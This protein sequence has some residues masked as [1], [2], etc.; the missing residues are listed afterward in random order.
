MP[1][2][3]GRVAEI[4]RFPVKSMQGGR[5][6]TGTFTEQGLDGDRRWALRDVETGRLVSA[7]QNRLILEASAELDGE[8]LTIALPDGRRLS[9]EDPDAEDTLSTWLGRK[10]VLEHA[11][12]QTSEPYEFY[13][14][15]EDETSEAIEFYTSE[16]SFMDAAAMHILTTSS[17]AAMR[18]DHPD[19]QWDVRRF[20]P[21]LVLDVGGDGHVE[22]AWV[23]SSLRIGAVDVTVVSQ[24][25]RCGMP[26]R[27][28][29]GLAVDGEVV[30][31]LKQDRRQLLGV[32]TTVDTPGAISEG[33]AVVA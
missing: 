29:P 26:G 24:T 1:T 22:D 30:R 20:R 12:P 8:R 31:I 5:V 6:A 3:V 19:N 18:A 32:Y 28:Q 14:D 33:D 23:G 7:K 15:P 25:I 11:G 9:P 2:E 17:L 27:G 13:V 4:W 21:T 16:G 10:V